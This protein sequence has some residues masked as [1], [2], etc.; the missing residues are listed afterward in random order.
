M[1][2]ILCLIDRVIAKVKREWRNRVFYE[3][4]GQRANLIGDIVL[5]N[6]NLKIGRNCC[7]YPYVQIFG[8]GLVEIGDNVDIDRYRDNNIC[9]K[10]RGWGKNW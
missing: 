2:R 6:R 3:K 9:F 10:M 4:T 1:M 5:I 8:D 7:I